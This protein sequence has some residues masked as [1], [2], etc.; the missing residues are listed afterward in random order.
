MS[1]KSDGSGRKS[2]IFGARCARDLLARDA[3]G[4]Q[5]LG[6]QVVGH[7]PVV[8]PVGRGAA[9]MPGLAEDRLVD[10][11]DGIAGHAGKPRPA[12]AARESLV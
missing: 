2:R 11:A 12:S 7:E 8:A 9:P 1:W 5:Q 6:D 3:A 4:E 10:A